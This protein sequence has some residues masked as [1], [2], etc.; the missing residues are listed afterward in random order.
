[1]KEF[2]L[3]I[4]SSSWCMWL[5]NNFALLLTIAAFISVIATYVVITGSNV[6]LGLKPKK[7][8]NY[9]IVDVVLLS[10]LISV[11]TFRVVKLWKSLHIGSIGSRLQ[12]RILIL[13]SIVAV[14]PTLI[15]SIFAT[16][17]FNIGIQTWFN[18]R[19][20]TAVNESL[21]VAEAYLLEHKD[22]IR[23]DAIAMASDLNQVAHLAITAP[24]EFNHIVA[25]QSTMRLLTES[26]VLRENRII[27]QGQLSYALAFEHIAPELFD[28]ADKGEVV[29][30][31]TEDDKVRALVK[32]DNLMGGY[33]LVGRLIDSKVLEHM[34]HTQGAVN[35]YN[36][37]KGHLG[38]LQLNFSLVFITLTLLLLVASIWYGMLFAARLTIP[39]SRLVVAAERV[40]GGDFSAQVIDASQKDEIGLLSRAFNRMTEQLDAQRRELIDASR[41]LDE[42]RRFSEAVLAGVSAGVIALDRDK[43]I[44]LFSR[45][46]SAIL[47]NVDLQIIPQTLIFSIL[48]GIEETLLQAEHFPGDIAQST[49]T[50]NRNGKTVTL[51]LRVTVEQFNTEIEGFIVTFDDITPLI[52][53]QRNAAWSDVARR[54]AH[55]IK[56]PLTPIQLAAERLKRKYL[57]QITED[58]DTFV[59]YTDTIS[60]HVSDIGRMVEEFVA[61]ARMPIAKFSN[62]D[63]GN[64]IKK[65]VFSAQIAN[66]TIDYILDVPDRVLSFYC[67]ERQI[68][69]VFTN[70][71]KN[72]TESIEV[73]PSQDGVMLTKGTISIVLRCSNDTISMVIEDNGIGFPPGQIVQMMDPYVTTRSKGTGLGLSIV[74]KIIED[75]KGQIILENIS[76][77]GARVILSFLQQCDINA[78]S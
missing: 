68:T 72:A 53:A 77:G 49:L 17:F 14:T 32:I 55:E 4:I 58:P 30:L 22:N 5:R 12:K 16:L 59:K 33:L 20:Q 78:A 67:D 50:L 63:I 44:T 47:A 43:M 41:R 25:T 65:S 46:A 61:F 57:K 31:T 36:T 24:T 37:L 18:D 60:K 71:L 35:E 45:S 74:K 27:A 15:I 52:A 75:H 69:Q 9:L 29:I 73:R 23:G 3:K 26:A 56:N 39:I 2:L 54:V 8:I 1:M 10:L 62:E 7:V 28:R 48:S 34:Q 11:I 42:R 51:H 13:F 76:E 40:R 64:I 6:Q 70:I 19:V 21:V 66:P 38:K